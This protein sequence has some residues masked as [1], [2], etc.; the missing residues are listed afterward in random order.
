M[1]ERTLE[2]EGMPP[3]VAIEQLI[4]R[5]SSMEEAELSM[6]FLADLVLKLVYYKSDMTSVEIAEELALPFRGIIEK[7]LEFLKR[8]EYVE[9]TGTKG[10]GERGFQW[11]ISGKGG[12]RAVQ[13]LERDQYIG[14]APVSLERYNEMVLRQ[15]VGELVVRPEDVQ[16]AL[17]HLVVAPRFINKIG[18]AVNSGR[19]FFLYGPPGNGKTVIAKSIVR[20]LKGTVYIPYTVMVDGQIIR[21]YD[22]LNHRLAEDSQD[23]N[24]GGKVSLGGSNHIDSRWVK[25]RRPEI[26]VG[27]E[28][29]M[30]NLDLIYDPISKTYEAPLQMKANTGLFV[31]DDFGRQAMRPQDLLNRWIVP[32]EL[33]VDFLTLQTGKKI[34]VPFDQ[35]IVFSTNLDPRDL[36]DDA[37]LRRIRH[38]LKVDNPDE[39]TYYQIMQ[40]ECAAHDLELTPDTFVYLM[41]TH[42]LEENRSL[43]CC[44]PRDIVDQIVDISTFFGTP[45]AL[46]KQLLD[47]ACDSYFADI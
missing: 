37:F 20:M 21:L 46:S 43:R 5:P 17:S 14:P 25:I 47:A 12:E 13:A 29:T 28:L 9:V 22:E 40:R 27:G 4:P 10:F 36:V 45:P 11:M 7:V 24:Q 15:T 38:K 35:L 44:H 30:R 6:G 2:N 26:I 32:L 39:K 19:S 8:E 42:Y 16:R 18:P 34:E 33:R 23:E 41:Q 31:I 3:Q 1:N